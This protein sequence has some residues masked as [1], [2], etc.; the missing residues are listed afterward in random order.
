[1]V[2]QLAG[3]VDDPYALRSAGVALEVA[4]GSLDEAC[5]Y[6]AQTRDRGRAYAVW[7][8]SGGASH[9][10]Q[11]VGMPVLPVSEAAIRGRTTSNRL[12][13]ADDVPDARLVP[14][15][16]GYL[17]V[18]MH[19]DDSGTQA[20][21]GSARIDFTLDEVV[22]MVRRDPGWRSRQV[23]LMSCST[24]QAVYAQELADRLGV[25]VYAP[26]DVLSVAG[27]VKTVLNGGVWVRVEPRS[28][29]RGAE[30]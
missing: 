19:G 4:A 24:G 10:P 20:A 2:H 9:A 27:G 22:E 13:L 6:A 14:D 21:I 29:E 25:A 8:A 17:D 16:A 15:F 5:G 12:N 7:L 26:S 30:S 3:R 23:R 28:G 18:V 11:A 1:M